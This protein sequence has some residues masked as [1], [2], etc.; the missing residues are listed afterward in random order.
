MGFKPHKDSISYSDFLINIEENNSTS[1]KEFRAKISEF[2]EYIL[3]ETEQE[4]LQKAKAK[5]DDFILSTNVSK[6]K[7]DEKTLKEKL[8]PKRRKIYNYLRSNY[9]LDEDNEFGLSKI[10]IMNYTE[11]IQDI[12]NSWQE[13]TC[14][15]I[16]LGCYLVR[17][18][19]AYHYV[20]FV[21]D[22]F[23]HLKT[24]PDIEKLKDTVLDTHYGR[25]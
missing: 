7:L 22:K 13:H 3:G 11:L 24:P 8:Y 15:R 18:R 4:V 12:I 21:K 25:N 6:E 5:I 1:P 2:N 20:L 10:A 9:W 17:L 23:N 19:T 16:E 14:D